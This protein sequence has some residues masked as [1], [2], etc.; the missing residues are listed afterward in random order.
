MMCNA[1]TTADSTTGFATW[2]QTPVGQVVRGSCAH[3][4]AVLPYRSC[5]QSGSSSIFNDI[6]ANTSC[7]DPATF[8]FA[9]G[10][11][12]NTADTDYVDA[13][14]GVLWDTNGY[15][16][17]TLTRSQ[18]S[19]NNSY[20]YNIYFA[21]SAI[22]DV[23]AFSTNQIIYSGDVIVKLNGTTVFNSASPPSGWTNTLSSGVRTY[24]SNGST[25]SN[26]MS[27]IVV[28]LNTIAVQNTNN[29]IINNSQYGYVKIIFNY[30]PT[31]W[32]F[33]GGLGDWGS[34]GIK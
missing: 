12:N 20:S 24:F 2:P 25:N 21:V 31:P 5:N 4:S 33:G 34:L 8:F 22:A 1:I 28:G 9:Y 17:A 7:I 19:S 30:T 6:T 10:V 18:V 16:N 11:Y 27:Y 29:S 15:I 26:L 14:S 23:T 13:S 3:P 32:D